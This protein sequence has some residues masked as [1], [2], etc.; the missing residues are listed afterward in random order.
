MSGTGREPLRIG[1]MGAVRITERS[2]AD[3]ARAGGHRLVA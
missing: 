2:L 3:P 1:V